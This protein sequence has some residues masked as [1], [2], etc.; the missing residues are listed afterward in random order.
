MPVGSIL[1]LTFTEKAAGE[2]RDRVRRRFIALGEDEHAR[3]VDA[4]WI[5]T[6]HGFCARVLRSRPL[7]AGPR[8]ALRGAR[9][10]A[11]R[12][13]SPRDAYERA[14]RGVGRGARARRR[15]T[16][17]AAFGAGLRD[18]R[19][20]RPLDAALARADAAACSRCRRRGRRRT[21]P[22][23]PR[24]A[25]RRPAASPPPAPG[26]QLEEALDALESCERALGEPRRRA[27]AGRARAGE[28]KKGAK[29][30]EQA[31]VRG[32]PRRLDAPTARAAPTTTRGPRWSR[33]P[34]CSTR[35]GA[36]YAEAK[37][38]RAG[39]RLRGPRARRPRPARRRR[40]GCASAGPSASR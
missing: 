9:R 16:L 32:L 13:G 23:S 39:A 10:G 35:F 30:L 34:T 6:I 36:A 4:G 21:R 18:D 2:L 28:L 1:A 11:P 3:A 20:R 19:A 40:R 15:S 37:A 14:L 5:G 29:A 33:S 25:P 26:K 24:R 38:A 7:A 8:P 31:A 27:G 12:G 17:A 22:R